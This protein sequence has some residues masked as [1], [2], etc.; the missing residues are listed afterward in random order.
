MNCTWN[1]PENGSMSDK[2]SWHFN[3]ITEKDK[4]NSLKLSQ[5]IPPFNNTTYNLSVLS[6][7]SIRTDES[8]WYFC[9]VTRDIPFLT[10]NCSNG[11]HVLV[12]K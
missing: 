3:N 11:L 12:G 1:L 6:K 9:K 5:E 2:V 10:N 4:C 7:P 8:G